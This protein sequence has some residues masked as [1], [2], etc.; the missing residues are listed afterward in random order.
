[1]VSSIGLPLRE[2]VG[3]GQDVAVLVEHDRLGGGR[4]AVEADEGLDDLAGREGRR[5][6]LLALV[7]LLEGSQLVC[8]LAQA[9]APAFFFSSTR[10]TLM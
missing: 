2:L 9:C 10:P 7:P 1:M 5:D 6:E 3:L 4:A 8:R